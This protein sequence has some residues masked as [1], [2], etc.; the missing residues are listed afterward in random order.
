MP[1]KRI[2]KESMAL[3]V[4]VIFSALAWGGQRTNNAPPRSTPQVKSAPAP[5]QTQAPV[6][7]APNNNRVNT[8]MGNKSNTG[9]SNRATTGMGGRTTTGTGGRTTTGV[10]GGTTTGM[11]GR[12]TTGMGGRTTTGMGGGTA[13][14]MGGRRTFQNV[15]L[16]GGGTA[17]I[18]R[19]PNGRV[20][21]IR[22]NG[23]RIH[24]GARG[25]RMIVSE[26]NGRTIVNTGRRGGYVQRP[27][28]SRGGRAYYQR[29]YV[30]GGR[31]YARVYRGFDYRGVRYYGY[32]PAYYYH[33]HFYGWAYHPWGRV[34][35]SP[36]AWG[37]VGTPWYGFYGGWFTPY[38]VYPTA[39][40]WLTDYLIAANLQAAYQAQADANAAAAQA[41]P[42]NSGAPPYGGAGASNQTPLSPE[43]KQAIADEVQRQ[44]ELEGSQGQALGQT[45]M[46][47]ADD[48]L[49][50]SFAGGG[51]HV[52]VVSQGVDLTDV[53][54]GHP[55]TVTGG[56]VLQMTAPP[57]PGAN[58]ANV[59]VLASKGQDC[60]KGSVVSAPLQELVEMQNRMRETLDQGLQNLQSRQGQGGLPA[61]PSAAAAP[62]TDAPWAAEAQSDPNVAA[63]LQAASREAAQAEQDVVRQASEQPGTPTAPV[64]ISLG[65]TIAEV[66]AALGSPQQIVDLGSKKIYVY[67]DF[68]VTFIDGKLT[69]VQ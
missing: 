50:P 41:P 15:R 24:Q 25:G 68:K 35:F 16:R 56:D 12:T 29:T 45:S 11:G 21:D 14:G 46:A 39:A 10:G 61:L 28:I 60:R 58:A 2:L 19:R 33:P 42:D 37:W 65:Q 59:V 27:Y 3:L 54:D 51:S 20:A 48:T 44:L 66:E 18:S 9:T 53:T 43:V 13:T 22:A 55:C 30:V 17:Q 69:D 5:R 1:N 62:P 38:P 49:P 67:K 26:R 47:P 23:M 63:D 6:R 8:G 36:I 7:T 52:F 31:S 4:L 40:L 64:R 34:F 57:A 32:A